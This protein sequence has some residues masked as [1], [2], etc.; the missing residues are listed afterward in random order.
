MSTPEPVAFQITLRD[1]PGALFKVAANFRRFNL[2]IESITGSTAGSDKALITVTLRANRRETEMVE[3]ALQKNLDVIETRV[4]RLSDTLK[5]ELLVAQLRAHPKIHGLLQKHGA[6]VIFGANDTLVVE[7]VGE[8]QT[9][10]SFIEEC[11]DSLLCFSRTGLLV[12]PLKLE[13]EKNAQ[14]IL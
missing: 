12:L 1:R 7:L 10:E 5:R 4:L 14:N 8:P 9:I 2:N 3:H 13:A 6:R 11:S